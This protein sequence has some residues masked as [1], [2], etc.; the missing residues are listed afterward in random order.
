MILY[1]NCDV[2]HQVLLWCCGGTPYC[3]TV[4]FDSLENDSV[5]VRDRDSMER[6]RVKIDKLTTHLT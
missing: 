2:Q 4:D 5:T 3:V 6:E 1:Q